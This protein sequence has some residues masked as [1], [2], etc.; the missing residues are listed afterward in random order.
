MK[1][2]MLLI[3]NYRFSHIT[4]KGGIDKK[5]QCSRW[6]TQNLRPLGH[7]SI[8]A[9]TRFGR[10]YNNYSVGLGVTPGIVSVV[11]VTHQ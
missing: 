9:S 5:P 10:K 2:D 1:M 3:V 4:T 11:I 6:N 8:L 7:T